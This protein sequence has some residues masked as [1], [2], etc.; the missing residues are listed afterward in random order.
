MGVLFPFR[1]SSNA[2]QRETIGFRSEFEQPGEDGWYPEVLGSPRGIHGRAAA[3][4]FSP[5]W[6]HVLA[7]GTKSPSLHPTP[8][9][10]SPAGQA[11]VDTALLP[12]PGMARN[13]L[14][15]ETF[16]PSSLEIRERR[17][18]QWGAPVGG[19]DPCGHYRAQRAAHRN[20]CTPEKGADP[21]GM[22][23][24]RGQSCP[25]S[26]ILCH[27]TL[28]KPVTP[29]TSASSSAIQGG[30]N[31]HPRRDSLKTQP[32][33]QS[34]V[35]DVLSTLQTPRRQSPK[36][37]FPRF[38]EKIRPSVKCTKSRAPGQS[39]ADSLYRT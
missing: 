32:T 35:T 6:R 10:P 36:F 7:G 31:A 5:Q 28:A 3:P 17:H 34:L 30:R 29:R 38:L 39:R 15:Q 1:F 16:K 14:S 8:T 21:R 22:D 37:G 12:G 25:C 20:L 18:R 11:G 4:G 9:Y 23:R 33:P 24:T 27:A 26:H 19:R 13:S 2:P